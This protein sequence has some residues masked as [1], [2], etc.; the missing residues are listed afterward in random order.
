LAFFAQSTYT[1]RLIGALSSFAA[2][3]SHRDEPPDRTAGLLEP[4]QDMPIEGF[5]N[6][7]FAI[8]PL[9]S[10][11]FFTFGCL[12]LIVFFNTGSTIFNPSPDN[13]Y[14]SVDSFPQ[15]ELLPSKK[16]SSR[17]SIVLQVNRERAFLNR[18]QET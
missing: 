7:N 17:L 1:H 4:R 5:H 16:N 2:S 6:L 13:T 9:L 15:T 14:G 8:K 18:V 12:L 11:V 10:I 3:S